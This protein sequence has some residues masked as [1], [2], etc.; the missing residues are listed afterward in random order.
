M[1]FEKGLTALTGETGAGKSINLESLQLLFGKRSDA[2]MIR[3]GESKATVFGI[4]ELN[5]DQMDLLNL[6]QVIEV[7]REIDL[8]GRHTMRLNKELTTLSRLK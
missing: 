4:F 1:T 5:Q 7:E 3:H 8:Q 6:P 2:T